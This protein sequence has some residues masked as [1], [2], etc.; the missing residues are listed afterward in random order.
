[1]KLTAPPGSPRV[2]LLVRDTGEGI[3]PEDL[4]KVFERF[5][6]VDK[7]R[8]R[9][10]PTGGSGLGL[11]ICQAIVRAYG[12]HISIASTLG[13]GTAVTV[14]LLACGPAS[15]LASPRELR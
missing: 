8:Q 3:P 15:S 1:V 4:P 7:S 10:Q 12:G 9:T 13:K 11:S 6:R 5:Y 2:Q 14:S